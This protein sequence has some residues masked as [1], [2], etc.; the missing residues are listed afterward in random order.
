VRSIA[1]RLQPTVCCEKKDASRSD[2][3]L[4]EKY[5]DTV[6]RNFDAG[7]SKFRG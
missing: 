1:V 6:P 4:S 3:A 5:A 7:A 2:A